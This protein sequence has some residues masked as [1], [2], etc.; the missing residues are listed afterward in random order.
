[1]SPHQ[2]TYLYHGTKLRISSNGPSYHCN[3]RI[4]IPPKK[5]VI[6]FKGDTIEIYSSG[7]HNNIKGCNSF[8]CGKEDD[9]DEFINTL[10]NSGYNCDNII[11][12]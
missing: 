11:K 1:M 6:L 9:K 2:W 3:H 12:Y 4:S 5:T 10:K 7:S 8:W